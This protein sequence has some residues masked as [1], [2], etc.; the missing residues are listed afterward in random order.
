MKRK[1]LYIVFILPVL[2]CTMLIFYPTDYARTQITQDL[3]EQILQ[4]D[5]NSYIY[6]V[7]SL[8][9]RDNEFVAG[10]IAQKDDIEKFGYILFTEKEN[11]RYE[12]TR[13][14]KL[15]SIPNIKA[16]Y[17]II[18]FVS[19][20]NDKTIITDYIIFISK[21]ERIKEIRVSDSSQSYTIPM[22]SQPTMAIFKMPHN[23]YYGV[24]DEYGNELF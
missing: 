23:G 8:Q 1:Y 7:V 24:F 12:F 19:V 20:N 18:P 5:N 3:C 16:A 13:I 22:K 2:F 15:F 10:Y 4:S 21:D 17:N 9:Q 6:A 11:G 14:G